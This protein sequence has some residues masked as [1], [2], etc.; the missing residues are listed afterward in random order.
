MEDRRDEIIRLQNDIMRGLL[1]QRMK[2]IGEDLWGMPKTPAVPEKTD[3]KPEEKAAESKNQKSEQPQKTEEKPEEKT[4]RR[5][6]TEETV[7]WEYLPDEVRAE[8]M[9]QRTNEA[10]MDDR[11]VVDAKIRER[12]EEEGIS[13]SA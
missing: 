12:A 10:M 13:L 4:A 5:V 8:M 1:D 9:R 6:V 2:T 7:N 11:V 3:G